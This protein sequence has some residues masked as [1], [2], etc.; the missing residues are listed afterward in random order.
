MILRDFIDIIKK[1]GKITGDKPT[2]A[3]ELFSK[4]GLDGFSVHAMKKWLYDNNID[5]LRTFNSAYVSEVGFIKYLKEQTLDKW[6]D[7]QQAFGEKEPKF[8]NHAT[9]NADE[10]YKNL[11]NLFMEILKLEPVSL[12]H[13][14]PDEPLFIGR[15]TELDRIKKIYEGENYAVLTGIGGIGKSQ[16][17]LAYAHNLNKSEEWI[18]QHIICDNSDT[19]R[20]AIKKLEFVNLKEHKGKPGNDILNLKI[21]ALKNSSKPILIILDNLSREISSEDLSLFKKCGGHVRFLITSRNTLIS[22]GPR[23]AIIKNLEIDELREIYKTH[24][25]DDNL[26]SSSYIDEYI[27]EYT[28]IIDKLIN[29]AG[30][31]TLGVI[32]LAR[33]LKCNS[34]EEKDLYNRLKSRLNLPAEKINI[35]KDGKDINGSIE[36]ITKQIFDIS[37]FSDTKKDVMRAMTIVPIMGVERQ[38]FE[39]LTGSLSH[40]IDNLTK[41]NWII[42]EKGKLRLHPIIFETMLGLFVPEEDQTKYLTLGERISTQLENSIK[43]SSR[44]HTL[45]KINFCYHLNVIYHPKWHS[46][47][48]EVR[49]EIIYNIYNSELKKA[50]LALSAP[51]R[52]YIDSDYQID[53]DQTTE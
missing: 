14:L 30:K 26:Y 17:A 44:W 32:L 1:T 35:S 43:G 7:M 45:W 50:L 3:T 9:E 28:D 41:R 19:L 53:I 21:T 37:Q 51:V 16:T 27:N 18:I 8:V 29:W 34:M 6:Q 33:L 12:C 4:S 11:F 52:K 22:D 24:R 13:I 31:N 39:E 49:N 48:L 42:N 15:V 10:F 38:L 5:P 40:E 47:K 20:T 36:E 23:V 2:V 25:F 46:S